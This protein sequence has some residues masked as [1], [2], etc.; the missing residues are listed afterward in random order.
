M[1]LTNQ[2]MG[3]IEQIYLER[4][5]RAQDE[6]AARRRRIEAAVPEFSRLEREQAELRGQLIEARR[7]G[8]VRRAAELDKQ[9]KATALMKETLLEEAGYSVKDLE[10]QWTCK[11]C[12]D[13]GYVDG[14]KCSCFR[15]THVN[16]LYHDSAL[17][18]RVKE[19]SFETF[20]I[21]RFGTRPDIAALSGNSPREVM[22]RNL[23]TAKN[24]V[25]NF[26]TKMQ[27]MLLFGPT[28]TGKTFLC[29]CIAG[30]LMKEGYAI[31]YMTAVEYFRMMADMAFGKSEQTIEELMDST[32]LLIIDDL[33]TEIETTANVSLMEETIDRRF[34]RKQSTIIS[35][36][37]TPEDLRRRYIERIASRL[38][39]YQTLPFGGDDLRLA[40]RSRITN[41]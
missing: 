28:G 33:G 10:P 8:S 34:R 14:E 30:A 24:F 39:C 16:V 15:H 23:R 11:V 12:R 9:I 6:A 17:W 25:K 38:L 36:N 41:L 1:P 18:E 37:L 5:N 2:Q 13:R 40:S 35:T 32:D 29:N 19:E 3:Q 7:A 27:N 31:V 22:T 21:T 20:D 4:R 26:G